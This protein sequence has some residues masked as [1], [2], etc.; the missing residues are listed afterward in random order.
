MRNASI[1]FATMLTTGAMAET[2]QRSFD[3]SAGGRFVLD[4]DW[5]KVEVETWDRDAVDVVV[6]PTTEL[7]SLEFDEEQG[8]ITVRA[9]KKERGLSRWFR[10]DDAPF[11]QVTVP[12]HFDLDLKTAGGKIAIADIDGDVVAR[13]SGGNLVLGEVTGSVHG[14]T[15]GWFHPHRRSERPRRRP[16][17]G[18]HDPD[19]PRPM[20]PWTRG[21]PA[22]RST[23]TMHGDPFR[24]TRRGDPSSSATSVARSTRKRRE[25]PSTPRS[26][27]NPKA[28]PGCGQRGV[29]SPWRWPT[30]SSWISTRG[31]RGGRV[32]AD[33]PDA[34]SPN[35]RRSLPWWLPSTVADRNCRC[36]PRRVPSACHPGEPA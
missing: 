19:W 13:T 18:R 17:L 28:T 5:G 27:N 15:A 32:K 14:R 20:P 36:E 16:D 10:S 22:D 31:R 26:P 24:L 6:E 34:R 2:E 9:R 35:P 7:E 1:L 33:L 3:V 30:T 25:D 11:F 8:T 21:R 4:A 23:S 29:A 12:R